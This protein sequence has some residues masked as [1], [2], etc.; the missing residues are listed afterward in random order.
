[1]FQINQMQ[2]TTLQKNLQKE[3]KNPQKNSSIIFVSCTTTSIHTCYSV[4]TQKSERK[5]IFDSKYTINADCEKIVLHAL[6]S[7]LQ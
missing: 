3:K 2:T 7:R 6:G 4:C 1:M 5:A